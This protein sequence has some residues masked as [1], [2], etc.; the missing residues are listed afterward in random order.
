MKAKITA[1][2]I[3]MLSINDEIVDLVSRKIKIGDQ[4]SVQKEIT[5]LETTMNQLSKDFNISEGEVENY[6][7]A[8]G[9]IQES[10]NMLR[11]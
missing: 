6:Q 4:D 3:E 10:K 2:I 11:L 7:K 9:A 1:S 8:V 5:R